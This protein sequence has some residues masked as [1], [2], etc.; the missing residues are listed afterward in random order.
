MFALGAARCRRLKDLLCHCQESD[1]SPW[2]VSAPNAGSQH[3]WC[4]SDEERIEPCQIVVS[5][6]S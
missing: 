3:T 6:L 4:T 1:S 5:T 2:K